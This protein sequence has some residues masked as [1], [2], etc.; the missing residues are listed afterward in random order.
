[1]TSE[2]DGAR[3]GGRRGPRRA[4]HGVDPGP[5][6]VADAL[7]EVLAGLV[8]PAPRRVEPGRDS[9]ERASGGRPSPS[10]ATW[11]TVFSRWEEL[12]GPGVARHAW[13]LRL[14]ERALVVAV[15][16]PPWAT[17][18]RALSADILSRLS[19]ETGEP[20]E[21]LVVVVRA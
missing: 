20:L 15:D 16:R 8:P 1:V 19:E 13:P 14:E 3:G 18:V 11:G 17:Q 2:G 6:P 12:V 5:R 9:A 7:D 4:R 10:A 21:R